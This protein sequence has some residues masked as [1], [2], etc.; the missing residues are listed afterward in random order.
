VGLWGRHALYVQ[1]L[2]ALLASHG[3]DV[4][5]V[6]E[7]GTALGRLQIGRVSVLLAESPLPSELE[8][9]AA[10]G[11]P[12]IVLAER[13]GPEES[14]RAVALGGF[15][16][17]G[18]NGSLSDLVRA[19]RTAVERTVPAQ[20]LTRRQR[21]V[22]ELIAEGLD[23]T[24]IAERLG[25]TQRTAR[26]HVS[27][28]LERLGADNR[29]HAAVMA[30]RKGWI[31]MTLLMVAL[32]GVLAASPAAY[33]ATARQQIRPALAARLAPVA[34]STSAWVFDADTGTEVFSLNAGRKRTPASVEKLFT[35]A[36]AFDRLGQEFRF[37]TVVAADAPPDETGL[38]TG[39]LYLRGGGDPSF[40]T[41]ALGRLAAAVRAAGV[42]DVAG[43]VLGDESYFD[44]RRG[45]R[46]DRFRTSF[47]IG[48]LSALAFNEGTLYG[49]GHGFQSNPPLFVAQ[50]LRHALSA[51]GIQVERA[52]RAGAAPL[53]TVELAALQ[54]PTLATLVRHMNQVSDNYYA[55]T[56]VK[57]LGAQ[58]AGAGSTA[59]GV[60]VVKRF[61]REIGVRTTVV[62]GS[63]L[64]R[65]NAMSA[66]A[67]GELLLRVRDRGWFGS[68][69]RS[70]PLAGHTGTL[71]KRMRRTAA[72]G[73]CRAKTGTLI[74]VSALAGYCRSRS[75]HRLVFSLLM[76]GVDTLRARA[77]QDRVV[78]KLAS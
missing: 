64:S 78:A 36:T 2:A 10:L 52:A 72:S 29:T 66:R 7:P 56:L 50:R 26:A 44:S 35:T 28:V 8:S 13:A 42:R 62:D 12:T 51:R 3:A 55:E 61:Q 63:G 21:E 5:V 33:A 22:L 77:V 46:E 1:S 31:G 43:R 11:P 53:H 74:G 71:R 38:V 17:H 20:T 37:R 30:L 23:N 45:L 69:Y 57:G 54:S 19:I 39:G 60:S 25:I 9:V 6:E 15:A 16:L 68:F 4:H 67:V 70:L 48:P 41:P 32:A 14:A 59:A 75:G 34:N 49:F 58:L 24:Q 76:N 40:G 18:K 27:A 73:R 47:W 65:A